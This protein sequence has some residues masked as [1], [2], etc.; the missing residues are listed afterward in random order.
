MKE[1]IIGQYYPY[2][3]IGVYDIELKIPE[4]LFE[5]E[6]EEQI[7]KKCEEWYNNLKVRLNEIFKEKINLTEVVSYSFK[8]FSSRD[9][10][11]MPYKLD[12]SLCVPTVLNQKNSDSKVAEFN[13]ML[14]VKQEAEEEVLN[15][16][17][18]NNYYFKEN[19]DGEMSSF[20]ILGD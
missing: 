17:L 6:V 3:V 16:L 10:I 8:K 19:E 9:L 4:N 18:E 7:G 5:T 11:E 1:Y 14:E 12:S 15:Y 20:A 13:V 2:L